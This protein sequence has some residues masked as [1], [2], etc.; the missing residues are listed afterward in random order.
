MEKNHYAYLD[1]HA[2]GAK[3][4][5]SVKSVSSGRLKWEQLYFFTS[6]SPSVGFDSADLVWCPHT[7]RTCTSKRT[8]G[9]NYAKE[10][11]C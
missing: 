8:N 9:D 2:K 1:F 6:I 3:F 10:R 4:F 7:M 11:N 5:I